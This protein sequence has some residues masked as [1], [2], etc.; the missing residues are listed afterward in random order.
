MELGSLALTGGGKV[1]L[2]SARRSIC[3]IVMSTRPKYSVILLPLLAATASVIDGGIKNSCPQFNSNL[4]ALLEHT[5]TNM[6]QP[7]RVALD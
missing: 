2:G 7:R 6:F 1:N 5:Y 3:L 4:L